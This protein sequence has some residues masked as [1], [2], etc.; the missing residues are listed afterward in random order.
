MYKYIILIVF[1]IYYLIIKL[2]NKKKSSPFPIDVV[3]T[4]AG[5]KQSINDRLSNNDELKYSLRS[6]FQYMPWINH[7]YI[8]MNPPKKKPSWF[9]EKY[10]K[11]ITIIDH[12]DTYF[13][14][15]YL[16]TTNSH[17]IE[18]TLHNIPNLSEHFI[19]FND[20]FFIGKPLSYLDFFTPDAKIVYC[21]NNL[22]NCKNLQI[23]NKEKKINFKLPIHCGL[24]YHLPFP[25]KKNIIK[26]FNN[27]YPDYI[28]WIRS[29][30]KRKNDGNDICSINNLKD[31]CQQ[32]HS[33]IM[34]YAKDNDNAVSKKI[35]DSDIKFYYNGNIN[36]LQN[37]YSNPP[38]FFCINDTDNF[39]N[40]DDKNKYYNFVNNIL[41]KF[42]KKHLFEY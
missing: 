22:N 1:F 23:K 3:Y 15:Q 38:K 40:L 5:E 20:D 10:K 33:P 18:T 41:E 21:E 7:I 2:Y 6:I 36:E 8:L 32:Q 17:S 13:D 9:N 24:S 27:T 42:Y 25:N 16:P 14:K 30:K 39:K 4:W 12:Y 26:K 34:K 37:L 29:I 11:K 19:Y 31:W 28:H 35:L